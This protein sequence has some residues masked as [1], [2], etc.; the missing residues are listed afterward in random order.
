MASSTRSPPLACW[1]ASPLAPSIVREPTSEPVALESTLGLM[2]GVTY[3]TGALVA[4][5]RNDR[6]MWASH[7]G[8]LAEE[9]ELAG[10]AAHDDV[11]VA[12]PVP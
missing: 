1:S 10:K 5:E 2:N 12:R 11:V 9:I 3:D 7:A 8:F 6:A 4:V